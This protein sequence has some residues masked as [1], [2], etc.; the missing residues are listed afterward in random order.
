MFKSMKYMIFVFAVLVECSVIGFSIELKETAGEG[1]LTSGGSFCGK[2][3]GGN[4]F[5]TAKS[6][7][8]TS[9][10]GY[11]IAG[12]TSSFGKGSTDMWILKIDEFGNLYWTKT[13]GGFYGEG[14]ESI[15]QTLPDGGYVVAGY[16][17]TDRMSSGFDLW[18]LKLDG[19]GDQ[20]WTTNIGGAVYSAAHSVRQTDDGGYV[21]AGEIG[22]QN[23]REKGL[24][25]RLNA[26]GKDEWIH[27]FEGD[28]KVRAYSIL[29]SGDG[30]YIV[31]GLKGSDNHG[32]SGWVMK[33]DVFGNGVW[34][35]TY[36]ES[37]A[38]YSLDRSHGGHYIAAGVSRTGK[39]DIFV[40]EIDTSGKGIWS[41]TFGGKA[42]GSARSIQLC[43]DG[44]Y[45]VSGYTYPPGGGGSDAVI[46]KL[47][48]SGKEVWRKTFGGESEDGAES[49]QQTADGGYIVSGYTYSLGKG[50]G[51]AWVFKLDADGRCEW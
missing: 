44:G 47:D 11:I 24:V 7:H 50:L 37:Q 13:Y 34:E 41:R 31:A 8:Q 48:E 28:E 15:Q 39:G 2:T 10:G 26:D 21:I 14:A 18:I 1:V 22:V 12:T 51:D 17:E 5:D 38:L 30:G 45:I 35:N 25:A 46:L 9:D 3:Y 23:E 16:K 36:P 40:V 20:V 42:E 43:A 27:F 29:Q 19:S 4:T 49:V 32:F 6:A 33:L